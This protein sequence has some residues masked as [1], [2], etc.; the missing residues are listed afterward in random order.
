MDP[1]LWSR[2]AE[3]GAIGALFPEADGGFGGAGFDVA[4]VFEALGGGLVGGAF[5]GAL[6]V[7]RTL[8]WPAQRK[9]NTSPASSTAAPW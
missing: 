9:R 3:L 4:V 1:A 8:G 7:G 2:F 6:V 5:L